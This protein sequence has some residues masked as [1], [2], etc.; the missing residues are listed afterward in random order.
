MREEKETGNNAAKVPGRMQTEDIVFM[1]DWSL[2][3]L[4]ATPVPFDV[5]MRP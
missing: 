5:M 3:T 2:K 4:K 1:H